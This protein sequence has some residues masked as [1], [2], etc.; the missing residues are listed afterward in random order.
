MESRKILCIYVRVQN[1]HVEG[2]FH[3]YLNDHVFKGSL[4]DRGVNVGRR[5]L[6]Y[7]MFESHQEGTHIY[8]P[9][10]LPCHRLP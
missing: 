5:S 4:A 9:L 1:K 3:P 7:L 8:C 6:L 10:F 2:R